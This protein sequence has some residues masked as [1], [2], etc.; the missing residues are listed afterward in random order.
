MIELLVPGTDAI[1]E[2]D[3]EKFA[4]EKLAS[5]DDFRFADTYAGDNYGKPKLQGS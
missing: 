2:I 1:L 3:E 5:L 4:E